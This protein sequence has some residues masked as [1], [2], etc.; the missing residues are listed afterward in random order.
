MREA[1]ITLEDVARYLG[2]YRYRHGAA[3][4]TDLSGVPPAVLDRRV[5][6]AALPGPF[7]ERLTSAYIAALGP[8]IHAEGDLATP[9]RIDSLGYTLR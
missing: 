4:G 6:A 2:D 3:P 8:G 7:V 1:G 5:F 9:P